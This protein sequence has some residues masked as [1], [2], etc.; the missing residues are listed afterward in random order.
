METTIE[1]QLKC[2][3]EDIHKHIPSLLEIKRGQ[4]FQSVYY[5]EIVATNITKTTHK[6]T[7]S[8]YG[9]DTKEGLP[10]DNYYPRDLKLIGLEPT[11]NDVLYWF[12]FIKKYKYA[13][14]ELYYF[15]IYNGDEKTE[16]IEWDL[17]NPYLR[18]QSEEL[19]SFLFEE[20]L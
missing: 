7:Y 13:H 19:I 14:F 10:R 16:P 9:F 5:G 1:E 12:T 17:T 3:I 2:I 11:L 4:R 18:G 20:I 6:D 15:S 8:I